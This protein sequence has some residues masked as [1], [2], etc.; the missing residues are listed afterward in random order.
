MARHPL[1]HVDAGAETPVADTDAAYGTV[2]PSPPHEAA[3][4]RVGNRTF[5]FSCDV[6][7]LCLEMRIPVFME[8]P[9]GSLIWKARRLQRLL[10]QSCCQLL[11]FDCCQ[12]GSPWRKRTTVAAWG[13]VDLSRLQRRC[14][15]QRGLCSR[16]RAFVHVRNS[17]AKPFD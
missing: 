16:S 4:V 14:T 1:H 5:H 17:M 9:A 13:A 15:G 2:R 8:N 11:T 3:K 12:Y 6:I 7:E 10:Q